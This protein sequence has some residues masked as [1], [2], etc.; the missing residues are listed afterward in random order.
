MLI[1]HLSLNKFSGHYY[2]FSKLRGQPPEI[3]LAAIDTCPLCGH[4]YIAIQPVPYLASLLEA[5]EVNICRFMHVFDCGG[6]DPGI[7]VCDQREVFCSGCGA[8]IRLPIAEMLDADR[9]PYGRYVMALHR[10]QKSSN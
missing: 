3:S 7:Y 10:E 5:L 4:P 1:T 8:E 9:T 2:L 6:S